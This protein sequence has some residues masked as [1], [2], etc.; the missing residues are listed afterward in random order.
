M[1]PASR[2]PGHI[3][4]AGTE[5]GL[6]YG[7]R[8]SYIMER[9]EGSPNTLITQQ[10]KSGSRYGLYQGDI[11]SEAY[12]QPKHMEK[13]PEPLRIESG[14]GGSHTFIT[15]EFVSAIVEDRHPAVNIWEAVAYTL[16]GIIAHKSALRGGELLKIKD[17][18]KA[19]G[20]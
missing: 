2:L 18:G 11:K 17:C 13:L 6:F 19:A 3:A 10:E 16:P 8:M 12:A 5:R 1:P 20:A 7:D 14:H 4:A 15:H 9:P